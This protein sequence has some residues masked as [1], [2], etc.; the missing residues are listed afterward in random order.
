MAQKSIATALPNRP[1]ELTPGIGPRTRKSASKFWEFK[2]SGNQNGSKFWN[3][4]R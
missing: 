1:P 2:K 4:K 3:Q